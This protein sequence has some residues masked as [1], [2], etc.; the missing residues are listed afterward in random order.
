MGLDT[1]NLIVASDFLSKEE[2]RALLQ[3]VRDV[4]QANFPNKQIMILLLAP[5]L[6][7]AECK[8]MIESIRPPFTGAPPMV[9]PRREPPPE[10]PDSNVRVGG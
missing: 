10:Q 4:E 7:A 3:A 6:S 8:D 9:I 5:K 2:I 1:M